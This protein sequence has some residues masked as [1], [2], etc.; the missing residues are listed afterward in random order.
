MQHENGHFSSTDHASQIAIVGLGFV[1]LPLAL[2]LVD[3]GFTVIGID[4]D[5]AKIN[6]VENGVSYISG[7]KNMELEKAKGT[8]RFSVSSKYELL[9]SVSTIIICVPTH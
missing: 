7:I 9:E 6:Q 1:G 8:K 4:I 3:K 5:K 2:L